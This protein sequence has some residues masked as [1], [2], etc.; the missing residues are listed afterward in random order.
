[1]T[2]YKVRFE[3]EVDENQGCSINIEKGDEIS[4]YIENLHELLPD[5]YPN[6]QLRS[7]GNLHKLKSDNRTELLTVFEAILEAIL[8]VE[9]QS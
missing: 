7:N 5:T 2:P 3:I 1:M 6:V 8:N 4:Q 9:I